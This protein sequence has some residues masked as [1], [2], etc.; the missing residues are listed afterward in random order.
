[1]GKV[2]SNSDRLNDSVFRRFHLLASSLPLGRSEL[3]YVQ[4]METAIA[5]V[6]VQQLLCSSWSWHRTHRT[7]FAK[8]IN[9]CGSNVTVSGGRGSNLDQ[10]QVLCSSTL[11]I[12]GFGRRRIRRSESRGLGRGLWSWA[13]VASSQA[14]TRTRKT[15]TEGEFTRMR[16]RSRSSTL[17]TQSANCFRRTRKS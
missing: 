17:D 8:S 13:I 12:Y 10:A 2:C 4:R 11:S 14:P 5:R 6:Q 7:C 9:G 15:G 1:M 16:R 3:L